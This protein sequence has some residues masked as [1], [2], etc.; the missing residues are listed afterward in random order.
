[1]IDSQHMLKIVEN[2]CRKVEPKESDV[3]ITRVPNWK[4]VF[5]EQIGESGRAIMM[6]EFKVDGVTWW[7]G[8]SER[9]Q[10]VFISMFA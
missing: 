6:S 3:K 8:F 10:T 7:A 4:S 5:V 1:M 9:S 2:Y